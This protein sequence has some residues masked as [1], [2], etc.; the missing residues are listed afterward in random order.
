MK[1]VFFGD[2]QMQKTHSNNRS[3]PGTD[4]ISDHR[5]V[6][7]ILASGLAP[8]LRKE[9]QSFRVAAE[10]SVELYEAILAALQNPAKSSTDTARET[11]PASV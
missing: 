9:G 4:A 2:G 3:V 11:T 10:K 6:A 8:S 1:S 5:I 7:A